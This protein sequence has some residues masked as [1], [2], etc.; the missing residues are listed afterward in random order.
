MF[1]VFQNRLPTTLSH[2]YALPNLLRVGQKLFESHNRD[3]ELMRAAESRSAI[4]IA[5][6]SFVHAL[7]QITRL[8]EFNRQEICRR[9][10][11]ALQID[12]GLIGTAGGDLI[13]PKCQTI[14]VG[15]SIE[16]VV[17]VL[18]NIV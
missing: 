6:S 13:D 12:A 8:L 17:I 7:D 3:G 5:I 9:Y 16:K 2:D 15:C 11:D 14:R 18:A 4:G 10:V 1:V